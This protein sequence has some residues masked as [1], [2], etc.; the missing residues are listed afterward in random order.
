VEPTIYRINFE[1]TEEERK[2]MFC[3]KFGVLGT[4]YGAQS[5]VEAM[6]MRDFFYK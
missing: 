2:E 3:A 4:A 6:T 5:K 1:L